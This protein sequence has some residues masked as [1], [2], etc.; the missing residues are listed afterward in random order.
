MMN[1]FENLQKM[2][3]NS[4]KP[5]KTSK[6]NLNI[7]LKPTGCNMIESRRKVDVK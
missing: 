6:I 3:E 1:L 4:D 7:N 5:K 2:K